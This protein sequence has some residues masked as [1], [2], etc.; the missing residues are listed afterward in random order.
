MTSSINI[1]FSCNNQWADKLAVTIVSTLLHASKDNI[2]R[3]FILDGGITEENKKKLAKIKS[4]INFQIEYIPIDKEIFANA[5]LGHHF[6]IETY[7]RLKLPTLI[8]VNKL[9]YMDVDTLVKKDIN[10]LFNIDLEDYYA[11]AIIDESS[12]YKHI[13]RLSVKRYFNAGV[14]LLN[15]KKIR[16]DNLEEKF[17]D[18]INNHSDLISWVD[19]CVLNA[20]FAENVKFLDR[21]FN[22]QHHGALEPIKELY[23]KNKKE[24]VI[25]HYVAQKKPW[26]FEKS[27]DLVFEYLYYALKT[28][29]RWQISKNL[30]LAFWKKIKLLV[31]IYT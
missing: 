16:E 24:V 19:Q 28:P 13:H 17:F 21:K 12:Y 7:Y 20:V 6:T 30:A 5:P 10:E 27:I 1:S 2:Y 3:F 26:N 22:F 25:L 15:L 18:F 23:N 8:N 11:G 31:N 4:K 14:L 9:L 29:Y